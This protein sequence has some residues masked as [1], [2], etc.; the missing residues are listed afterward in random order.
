VIETVLQALSDPNRRRVLDV[1]REGDH[2]V[3]ALV[4]R[5]GLGQPGM[6][7]HLRVLREA[8]LVEVRKHAQQ[9]VYAL[10]PTA[11][12]PLDDWLRPYRELW[13]GSLDALQR[14]LD[15]RDDR[16]DHGEAP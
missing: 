3:G 13:N 1:L 4:D 11:L 10:R 9:R 16:D 7:K 14:H 15:D 2:A 12:T 8:G 6:S 5:V